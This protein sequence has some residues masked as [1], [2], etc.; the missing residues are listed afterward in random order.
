MLTHLRNLSAKDR[1]TASNQHL[2]YLL[3]FVAGAI[4]AGGF[5]A[6]NR[7]TSHMTGI[8]SE[9]A[10]SLVL[11]ASAI[12][13]ASLGALLTFL[14]G[15]MCSTM[16][17]HYSRRHHMQSEYALP[18]LI[19]A[20]LLL[21][22]GVVGAQ[23][24]AVDG[25][26]VSAT[27]MLL[28]FMM[29]LQNALVTKISQAEIRTT[30]VTGIVTDIGIELGRLLYWNASPSAEMPRVTANRTRLRVLSVLLL[31]FFVGGISGAWGFKHLGYI[32][33]MPLAFLLTALASMPVVNDLQD[34]VRPRQ[35]RGP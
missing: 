24:N 35:N 31:A 26:F 4:N 18:L 2:G 29:G 10:D 23:L 3:A 20:A 8:V 19:E 5:L 1:T 9:M 22:F 30:H 21:V 13:L 6:V 34:M 14:L 11:G 15:A 12:A 7:Y 33:T 16:L 25:L 32:A 17:V 27:V 28:S